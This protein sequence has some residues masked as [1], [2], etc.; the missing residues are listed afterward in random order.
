MINHPLSTLMAAGPRDICIITTSNDQLR[1]CR[2]LG[3]GVT[4][5][6]PLRCSSSPTARA[7]GALAEDPLPATAALVLGDNIF[8]VPTGT[9][10]R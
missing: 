2:L 1:T 3:T 8:H 5:M 6:N 10:L 7:P 9:Q 4:R